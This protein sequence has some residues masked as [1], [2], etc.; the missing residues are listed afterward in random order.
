VTS[1]G[2]VPEVEL[3]RLR[4]L[5]GVGASSAA[6]A[7]SQLLGRPVLARPPG[8]SDAHSKAHFEGSAAILFEA[9]G[10][11]SGVLAL[12]LSERSR[13]AVVAR[14]FGD[15]SGEPPALAVESALREIGNILASQMLSAMADDLGARILL[16]VPALV[17]TSAD[18]ALAA[19]IAQRGASLRLDSDL[20][21]RD[22]EVTVHLV[23]VPDLEGGEVGEKPV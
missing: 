3:E 6:S 10:D 1:S 15:L 7:L 14:L 19:R 17:L 4:E 9:T 5:A 21:D 23:F 16:S 2:A 18:D 22:G 12:V 8:V 13:E 20:R 11:L